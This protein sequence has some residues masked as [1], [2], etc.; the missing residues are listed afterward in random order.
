MTL[1]D[2]TYVVVVQHIATRAAALFQCFSRAE[3]EALLS[4]Y[5]D[6][7]WSGFVERK[8]S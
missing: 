3:A 2:P 6:H 4:A 1:P 8:Q 5:E 7:G